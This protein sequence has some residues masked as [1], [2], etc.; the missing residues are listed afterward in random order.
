M[1]AKKSFVIVLRIVFILFSLQFLRDAF[2][3]WDGYSYY[4]RFIDFLPDLSLSFILWTIIGVILAF[5]LWLIAYGLFII[6]SKFLTSIRLEHIIACFIFLVFPLLIKRTFLGHI[7]VSDVIGLS[8]LTTLIIGGVLVTAILWFGHKYIERILK[9]LDSRI[10]PLFWL[11]AFLLVLAVPFS[12]FKK[13]F[14]EAKYIPDNSAHVTSSDKKRPNIILVIM[15]TLTARDMQLYGYN[16]LTTPFISKWAKED[17]IVFSRAYSSA[18]WTTPG[19]MTLMTGQRPWTHK[20]WYRAY[21]RPVSNYEN[22]L[23]RVLRD[24]GYA[25]YGFVQNQYAHPE[26]LG[27]KD[28]F[29]I[30]DKYHTFWVSRECWFYKLADFFVNRPVVKMWIFGGGNPIAERVNFSCPDR[31]T[32]L[33]PPEMV[34]NRFLKYISQTQ[35]RNSGSGRSDKPQQPFF[36]WLHVIPPHEPY[37]PSK[38]YIG[39]FGDAE[40]FNTEKKQYGN[41][42][43]EA[44]YNPEKQADVNILRKR[45]DEFILHSDKQFELFLSRLAKIIDMSNTI[46]ILTSDHG[47][48]FSHGYLAHGGPHL[49]EPLVHIPLIIKM[50]E[51][52]NGKVIDM[53]VEQT[54]IAPTILELTN[55]P[56]PVWMEGRSLLPLF[57]GEIFAPRPVF[58]MHLIENRVIGNPP[59]TK[60]TIAVWDGDYKL[61]YYL[62]ETRSEEDKKLLLFN[63][64]SDPDETLNLLEERPEITRRLLKL[65]N[66][67]LSRA[68]ARITQTKRS[69]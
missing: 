21:Y 39:M 13:G 16:R 1:T 3:K 30:K 40:K 23:Q 42:N 33:V 43:F 18:N 47:E 68:N 63:L 58:S 45:Y 7:S 48:S 2:Y 41:F 14:P 59:I 61:I 10:T 56:V 4:M 62:S 67:N 5:V 28:A 6:I 24:Y 65:I 29:L 35:L 38:L 53:P 26:T 20:V 69:S 36:A 17:A 27:I 11:F 31:Y 54:D 15:D 44:E 22:N 60:G 37:L 51:G 55:I 52:T 49:Y 19:T 25:V 64:R 8:H 50:P 32:T 34:Y 57:E 46:I 9:G 66:D 12:I